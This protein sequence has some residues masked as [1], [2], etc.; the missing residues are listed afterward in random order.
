MTM[1]WAL[2]QASLPAH[3]SAVSAGDNPLGG[4]L[5]DKLRLNSEGVMIRLRIAF[6]NQCRTCMA[7]RYSA[8]VT[9]HGLVCS[10]ER[11]K[12]APDLTDAE[13]AALHFA[14]LFATDHLAIDDAVYDGLRT[15]F[16]EGELVE[17]GIVCAYSVGFGRLAATWHVVENLPD[18]FKHG[19][20]RPTAIT[21]WGQAES[22]NATGRGPH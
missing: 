9:D 2:S 12:D 1:S 7:M 6:H 13:R 4:L 16:T 17:I 8:E 19:D 22:I 18:G 14:D 21:P 20:V 11:P 3:H 15:Y 5:L 10:L